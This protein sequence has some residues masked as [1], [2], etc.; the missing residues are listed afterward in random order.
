MLFLPISKTVIEMMRQT[1]SGMGIDSLLQ[2]EELK[3]K[4]REFFETLLVKAGKHR[5]KKLYDLAFSC[6]ELHQASRTEIVYLN[7]DRW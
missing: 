7:W 5:N 2:T 6:W 4:Q 3:E 1:F